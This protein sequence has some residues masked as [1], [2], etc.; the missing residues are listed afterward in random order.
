[1]EGGGVDVLEGVVDA[2]CVETHRGVGQAEVRHT[3]HPLVAHRVAGGQL[4]LVALE[5]GGG[6]VHRRQAAVGRNGLGGRNLYGV[7]RVQVQIQLLDLPGPVLLRGR[8]IEG[9]VRR[10]GHRFLDRVGQKLMLPMAVLPVE[11]VGED[12][13]G[14]ILTE[15][16]HQV[17]DHVLLGK[18]V[19]ELGVVGGG[20]VREGAQDG[21]VPE[22]HDPGPVAGLVLADPLPGGGIED[23]ALPALV[24]GVQGDDGP[25]E[26]HVVVGVHG[27]D[28]IVQL[29]GDAFPG[30]VVGDGAR[31]VGVQGAEGKGALRQQGHGPG[32]LRHEHGM[33]HVGGPFL[34]QDQVAGPIELL[35]PVSV[36]IVVEGQ[37]H[38]LHRH[39]VR[40]GQGDP[41][42]GGELLLGGQLP[43][44]DPPGVSLRLQI[45]AHGAA[46]GQVLC[47]GLRLDGIGIGFLLGAGGQ[48]GPA[49]KE[50]RQGQE[51]GDQMSFHSVTVP[52]KHAPMRRPSPGS[53]PVGPAPCPPPRGRWLP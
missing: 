43:V 17:F 35:H 16:A 22:P 39:V 20:D 3:V 33:V 26:Q 32:L 34:V 9:G 8:R 48:A 7:F 13:L 18:G 21:G 24:H 19:L 30:M 41:L 2:R 1:M 46:A 12:H 14:P 40:P 38:G 28:Q 37:K 47:G 15:Q 29:L 52:A 44:G 31:P 27:H 50:Q 25:H 5:G 4:G 36:G 51:T 53:A 11:I 45:R 23:G 42:A 49:Q 10:Q 6:D